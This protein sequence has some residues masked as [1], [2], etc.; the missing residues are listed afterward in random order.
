MISI[1][2]NETKLKETNSSKNVCCD[3]SAILV[4]HYQ[5]TQKI[6]LKHFKFVCLKCQK[7][8]KAVV[9]RKIKNE[10]LK[11]N[12]NVLVKKILLD[13]GIL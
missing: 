6:Y 10:I 11:W 2:N 1:K 12:E 4:Y 13:N 9:Q 8:T 7:L 3:V 5:V